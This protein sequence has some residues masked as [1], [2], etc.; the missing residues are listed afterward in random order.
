[1]R[2][3]MRSYEEKLKELLSSIS[4]KETDDVFVFSES[5]NDIDIA[6]IIKSGRKF[7][8]I[9]SI[10]PTIVNFIKETGRFPS[11]TPILTET[12]KNNEGSFIKN[13]KSGRKK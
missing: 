1:M 12:F 9:R 7:D 2:L 3:A 6:A 8:Y 5:V 4:T 10:S 13:V 11:I